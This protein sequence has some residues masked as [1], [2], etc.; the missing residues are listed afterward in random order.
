MDG[1]ELTR[2]IRA[3]E[4]GQGARLPIVAFTANALADESDRCRDA[5]MDDYLAK[6]V[7]IDHLGQIVQRWLGQPAGADGEGAKVEIRESAASEPTDSSRQAPATSATAAESVIDREL[8]AQYLGD[9]EKIQT[10]FLHKFVS[11]S[12]SVI[13]A[14]NA[15]VDGEAW[16]EVGAQAHKL[17]SSS[18]SVGAVTLAELCAELER[19]GKRADAS[20][21]RELSPRLGEAYGRVRD[22]VN[23]GAASGLSGS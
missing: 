7:Q 12:E 22:Y 5:G 4:A 2:S 11:Q 1:Y 16:A 19:A 21:V 17:K 13:E 9:D 10:L 18:R 23:N 6:P 14:V 20:T 3:T 8:L 15:A